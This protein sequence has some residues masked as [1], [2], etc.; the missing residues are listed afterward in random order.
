MGNAWATPGYPLVEPFDCFQ[1]WEHAKA[2]DVV[3]VFKDHEFDFGI[4]ASVVAALLEGDRRTAERV[5]GRLAPKGCREINGLA[6]LACLALASKGTSKGI[7]AKID[8]VF[9]AFDLEDSSTLSKDEMT[10]AVMSCLRTLCAMLGRGLPPSDAACEQMT[11]EAYTE[12]AK[13]YAARSRV[14]APRRASMRLPCPRRAPNR[15]SQTPINKKEFQDFVEAKLGD[16]NTFI[17]ILPRFDV[18]LDHVPDF[19]PPP[20]YV[21]VENDYEC[22]THLAFSWDDDTAASKLQAGFRGHRGR[23]KAQESRRVLQEQAARK[24][25]EEQDLAAAR[26]QA[27]CHGGVESP[28]WYFLDEKQ[29]LV[30]L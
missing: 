12:S 21:D 5:V 16:C 4:D 26:M 7:R 18:D 6:F 14:R 2:R 27:R 19:E 25:R 24:E 30:R 20:D 13:D 10:I 3:G 9:D 28:L 1:R 8:L 23:V 22:A 11:N 29:H 17:D 15:N